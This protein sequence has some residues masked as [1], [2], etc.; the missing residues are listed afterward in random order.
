[1]IEI[2]ITPNRGD[3]LGVYGIARDLAAAGVGT[4][5]MLEVPELKGSGASPITVTI[6][7]E[8]K[9]PMFIGRKI[10]GVKNAPPSLSTS[11]LTDATQ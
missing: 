2:A 11:T 1:M 8:D 9:A 6:E 10:T 5:K 3:C 7:N 4:L